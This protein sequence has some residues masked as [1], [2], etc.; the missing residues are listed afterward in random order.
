MRRDPI[1]TSRIGDCFALWVS[2]GQHRVVFG[3]WNRSGLGETRDPISTSRIGDC[4]GIWGLGFGVWG[5]AL[6]GWG[7][8]FVFLGLG[9]GVWGLALGVWGLGFRV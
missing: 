8:G 6:G 3:Y 9:F 1:I 2:I 5:L 4:F 7:F